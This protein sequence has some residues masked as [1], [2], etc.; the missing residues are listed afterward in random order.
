MLHRTLDDVIGVDFE[1]L[2][3]LH[4]AALP[5]GVARDDALTFWRAGLGQELW[6]LEGRCYV[7]L[8]EHALWVV[9]LV[10]AQRRVAIYPVIDAAVTP[11]TLDTVCD[12]SEVP[13]CTR[14]FVGRYGYVRRPAR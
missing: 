13:A 9:T 14:Q 3:G 10:F 12:A 4:R 6:F 11:R 1:L 5:P 7:L 8:D 2:H